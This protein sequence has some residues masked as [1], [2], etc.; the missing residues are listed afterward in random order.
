MNLVTR[1]MVMW[2]GQNDWNF[3]GLDWIF[4]EGKSGELE[5]KI[6]LAHTTQGLIWQRVQQQTSAVLSSTAR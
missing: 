5:G 6:L 2:Y 3:P 4:P 1:P